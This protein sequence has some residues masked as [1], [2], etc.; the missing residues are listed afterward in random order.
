MQTSSVNGN[1]ETEVGVADNVELLTFRET[2]EDEETQLIEKEG[3]EENQL[4]D[5]EGSEEENQ[6]IEEEGDEEER[7]LLADQ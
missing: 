3:N 7:Q 6:I 1:L 2:N 5:K 4:I